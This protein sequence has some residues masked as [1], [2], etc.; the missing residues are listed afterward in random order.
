M[1]TPAAPQ[2][3]PLPRWVW[4]LIVVLAVVTA[5][6]VTVATFAVRGRDVLDPPAA[7]TLPTPTLSEGAGTTSTAPSG[8]AA[9]GCLGGASDLD[10]AVI[11]AQEQAPRTPEGAAAFTATLVRWA[12][13]GPPSP[14]QAELASR[15]LASGAS[16]AAR[17]SLSS[18]KT[19]TDGS[20]FQ[21]SFSSGRYYVESFTPSLAIISWSAI[22]YLTSTGESSTVD[23]GGT[24]HLRFDSGRWR[25]FDRT[26]D[27][28]LEDMA[29]VGV[30]YTG[31]C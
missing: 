22:G 12:Y 9:V 24:M 8:S 6:A 2:R 31:G 4:A 30:R 5:L 26:G 29:S 7:T 1:S 14:R 17:D 21:V 3:R 25:Y 28:P 19:V 27:R 15:I 23:I 13:A 18:S 10:A 20:T 16:Q 11:D